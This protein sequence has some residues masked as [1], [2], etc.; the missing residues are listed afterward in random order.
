MY[1]ILKMHIKVVV[2]CNKNCYDNLWS[3]NVCCPACVYVDGLSVIL[4]SMP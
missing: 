2:T 3:Q 4:M 1:Q